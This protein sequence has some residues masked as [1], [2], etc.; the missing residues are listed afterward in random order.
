[1]ENTVEAMLWERN[2]IYAQG[3]LQSLQ[4]QPFSELVGKVWDDTMH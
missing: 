2:N 1:M 4:W 3:V